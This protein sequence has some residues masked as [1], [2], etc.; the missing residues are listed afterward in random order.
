MLRPAPRSASIGSV[1]VANH[2]GAAPNTMPVSSARPNAK[3]STSGAGRVSIGRKVVPANASA[4][5][6]R[7]VPTAT[8]S[9]AMPPAMASRMLS[10]SAC[11]TICRREAPIA[12]RTRRLA[13]P[14]DRAREQQVGDVGAGD[15]QH[16]A[17]HAEEDLQAA[18]VPAPS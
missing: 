17:A 18:A 11:V 12:S 4:S 13:A 2:A 3:P 15:Q 5:S 9:P 8:T 6:S 1:R 16:Q 10:T 14:R 7:A